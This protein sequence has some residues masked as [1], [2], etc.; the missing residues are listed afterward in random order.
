M[1][2]LRISVAAILTCAFSWG[3]AQAQSASLPTEAKRRILQAAAEAMK[4]GD[5]T[6]AKY[7]E[8]V[9]WTSVEPC[10]NVSMKVSKPRELAIATAVSEV[11]G[12]PNS[13]VLGYFET[14]GWYIVF[15]NASPGDEQYLVYDRDP[16]THPKPRTSWSGAATIFE[17]SEI[18][19]WLLSSASQVPR[20]LAD[21]FA[22]QVTLGQ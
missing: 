8:L 11:Q 19:D 12:F 2:P 3:I 20:R 5:I 18:R 4:A 16:V 15:T 1:T 10:K 9:H 22:W 7:A 17:T 13:K 14:Q 6:A 21:C